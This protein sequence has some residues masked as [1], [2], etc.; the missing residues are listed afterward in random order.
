MRF[1][2]ART[3]PL[4]VIDYFNHMAIT[5]VIGS[6]GNEEI[7][8]VARYYTNPHNRIAEVA[9]TVQEKWRRRG[10]GTFLLKHL[11]KI[12]KEHGVKGFR[13]E[14]LSKNRAMMQLFHKSE[15]AIHSSFE[16]DL[17]TMWYTFEC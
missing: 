5:A 10:L 9:F 12:A 11:T 17:F 14:I 8:G 2:H 7:I 6:P 13:A 16:D 4:T 1:S 15:C 3:L